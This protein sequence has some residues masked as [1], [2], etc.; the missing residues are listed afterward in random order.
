MRRVE[1]ENGR[2]SEVTGSP[3][4]RF[5]VSY[6]GDCMFLLRTGSA[7]FLVSI[8][9][10]SVWF[11]RGPAAIVTLAVGNILAL[12]GTLVYFRMLE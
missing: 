10:V 3:A 9:I 6:N 7:I 4:R 12:G 8:L 2:H 5:P 11:C 1:T